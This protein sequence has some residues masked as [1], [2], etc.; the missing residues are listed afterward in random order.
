MHPTLMSARADERTADLRANAAFHRRARFAIA[1]T[2]RR[3]AQARRARTGR[4]APA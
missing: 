2:R 1:R 3:A 4:V